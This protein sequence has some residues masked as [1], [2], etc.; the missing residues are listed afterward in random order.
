MANPTPLI[1]ALP[2]PSSNRIGW[3]WTESSDPMPEGMTNGSHWPKIS[4]VTPSYN[5]GQFIEE[6]IRSVLLQGYPNLE[7]IIID[8]GSTDNTIEIIR[9]YEPWLA[10]WVSEPDR[11]QSHAINKGIKRATGETVLWLNSDDLVLPGAFITAAK[12]FLEHP[13]TGLVIGQA[14]IINTMGKITGE[15]RSQFSSWEELATNPRNSVR[16]ISTFF[17][18][19]L[20]KE[21][22]FI[23]ETLHIAMDTELLV[24][25]TR[26]YKPVIIDEYLTAFRTHPQAKTSSQ[27]I[28][29]YL[30]TDRVRPRF[31]KSRKMI[32]EYNRRSANNWLSL[33]EAKAYEYS[34]RFHC[35]LYALKRKPGI[36]L[37]HRFWGSLRK[38]A[39]DIF[40][41][42]VDLN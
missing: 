16:Q 32:L 26:F 19:N 29:G 6:T 24:R 25:F 42:P 37:N 41:K 33:S 31:L 23:D 27:L 13:E 38:L 9:K 35:L 17:S 28:K 40:K 10:Y 22:G 5:Q 4:V 12:K 36:I 39:A 14:R 15:L 2:S 1:N 30:E 3:P 34:V 8:G 18:R 7:F 21:L 20:F 11:G